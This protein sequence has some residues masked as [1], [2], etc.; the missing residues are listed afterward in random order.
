MLICAWDLAVGGGRAIDR[1]GQPAHG[2]HAPGAEQ[3]HRQDHLLAGAAKLE[4]PAVG[5]R[6][7]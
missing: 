2:D 5:R 7:R 4:P 6:P 1:L 3:Q